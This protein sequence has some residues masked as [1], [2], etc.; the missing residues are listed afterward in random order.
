MLLQ[1]FDDSNPYLQYEAYERQL[2]NVR[3]LLGLPF[4]VTVRM[5]A[6]GLQ[7]NTQGDDLPNVAAERNVFF[8]TVHA[9]IAVDVLRR[10]LPGVIL[11]SAEAQK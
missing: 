9:S 3:W 10:M 8:A 2:Q 4:E 5:D 6:E 1:I 7:L 11:P